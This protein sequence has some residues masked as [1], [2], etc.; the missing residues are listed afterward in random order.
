MNIAMFS[1]SIVPPKYYGGIERVIDW[2]VKELAS[3]GHRIYF[4]SKYSGWSVYE[5]LTR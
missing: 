5:Y 4:V 2:L 3:M 1:N